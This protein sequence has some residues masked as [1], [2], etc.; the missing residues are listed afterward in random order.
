MTTGKLFKE[1]PP[2]PE[3]LPGTRR[4]AACVFALTYEKKTTEYLTNG[5]SSLSKHKTKEYDQASRLISTSQLKLSQAL[6]I[7]PIYLVVFQEPSGTR[8]SREI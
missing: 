4:L 5:S 1:Q 7:W 6:H 2:S 3:H 8:R